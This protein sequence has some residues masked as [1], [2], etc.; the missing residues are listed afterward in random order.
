MKRQKKKSQK[1]PTR[2]AVPKTNAAATEQGL[3]RRAFFGKVRNLALYGA[4]GGGVAWY[5]VKEVDAAICEG[6][7]SRIGNGVPTVVQ[8]H[9]PQCPRCV[10][11]QK[12]AREAV[13]SFE[14]GE[15]QFLVAN[16]R[17]EEGRRLANKHRVGHVTLLL[18]DGAGK[19]R[20]TIVGPNTSDYLE[21]QFQ[22]HVKSMT[23][24]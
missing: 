23:S 22:S 15:L 8:V 10:A 6:D 24:K 18:L 7:L 1:L 14:D 5:F 20:R 21:R 13:S 4:I 11:L 2:Q 17:T 12:E 19:R 9:D 3:D 16:I